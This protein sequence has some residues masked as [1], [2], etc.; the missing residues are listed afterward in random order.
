MIYLMTGTLALT[1]EAELLILIPS[2]W[3]DRFLPAQLPVHNNA[4][5]IFQ[6]WTDQDRLWL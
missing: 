5:N 6:S 3:V 4:R 1:D 2:R